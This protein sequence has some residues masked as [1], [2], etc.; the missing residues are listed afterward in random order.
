[1]FGVCVW[2]YVF[3]W[4]EYLVYV[5]VFGG[6]LSVFIVLCV[7]VCVCVEYG[8]CLLCVGCVFGGSFCV[9]SGYVCCW[10]C[11]WVKVMYILL[12]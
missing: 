6:V 1:V 12:V 8:V 9:C 7:C 11:L 10:V 2:V 4:W 3:V 5:C